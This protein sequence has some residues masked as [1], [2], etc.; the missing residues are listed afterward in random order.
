M[1]SLKV[2]IWFRVVVRNEFMTFLIRNF[3]CCYLI[4]ILMVLVTN[5]FA[6]DI[7]PHANV[8]AKIQN[9]QGLPASLTL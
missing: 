3:C 8:H 2:C 4:I 1:Y 6:F 9:S 7:V 5:F